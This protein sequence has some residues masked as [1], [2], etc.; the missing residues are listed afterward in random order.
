MEMQSR[1]NPRQ[2]ARLRLLHAVFNDAKLLSRES[3][4]TAAVG[5]ISANFSRDLP[6]G[7]FEIYEQL[8]LAYPERME[9]ACERALE[10][11]TWPNIARMK[12]LLG[13]GRKQEAADQ[14]VWCLAY[15]RQH[16]C[17]RR[18]SVARVLCDDGEYRLK[19]QPAPAIP[20]LLALTLIEL[21]GTGTMRG[22]LEFLVTHPAMGKWETE[23]TPVW[24]AERMEER[25][26][27]AYERAKS[28]RAGSLSSV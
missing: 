18:D 12:E 2:P 21:G 26:R 10:E 1:S 5:L 23:M 24:V 17:D 13:V 4:V 20:E 16:G 9:E 28:E 3:K 7:L 6:D 19:P 8:L 11:E 27:S 22:G 14:L 25:F 15:L